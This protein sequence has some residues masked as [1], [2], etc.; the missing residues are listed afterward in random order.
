MRLYKRNEF[1]PSCT[2][3]CPRLYTGFPTHEYV[4]LQ[5]E[6]GPHTLAYVCRL[7]FMMKKPM[8]VTILWKMNSI[9]M[10]MWLRY[11]TWVLL[12]RQRTNRPSFCDSGGVVCRSQLSSSGIFMQHRFRLNRRN[13]IFAHVI[14]CESSL[15]HVPL[16]PSVRILHIS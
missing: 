14:V 3:L 4:L 13:M 6:F 1:S 2:S 5:V 7:L 10:L 15:D 16:R 8:C 11:T 9:V 12:E